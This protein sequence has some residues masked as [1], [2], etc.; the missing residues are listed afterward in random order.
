[1]FLEHLERL[2]DAG[3]VGKPGTVLLGGLGDDPF[4]VAHHGEA[5]RV[6]VDPVVARIVVVGLGDDVG[7]RRQEL[8]EGA[9]ADL[10]GFVQARHDAVMAIGRASLVHHLGLTLRVEILRDQTDDA[11]DLA[12]PGLQPRRRLFQEIEDILLGEFEQGATPRVHVD[13]GFRAALPRNG[14]PKVVEHLFAV[15]AALA[16]AA[17]FRHEVGLALARIAVDAVVHQRVRG[18]EQALDRQ[19]AV[20]LLAFRDVAF[21]EVEILQ[22][23]VGIRPLLEQIVVLEEMVVAEGGVGDDQRLHRRRV[24]FHDVADARVGV[25]HDLIGETAQAFLVMGFVRDELLSER[26][27]VVIQ[28]HPDGRICVE[29]L[30]GCDD[31][32]L[33][34]VHVESKAAAGDLL[35]GVV[36]VLD[37]TDV[38]I[39]AREEERALAHGAPC[40]APGALRSNSSRNTG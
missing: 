35:A 36:D 31:L 12:L 7:V 10:P 8:E 23:A 34:G 25:D 18:I 33:V 26:P 30:F 9:V 28:R 16:L 2:A 3:D 13:S 1:M 40:A 27:M 32:D 5:E 21:R 4:D 39:G 15:D 17:L 11:D 14:A 38:P 20:A 24:F 6:G 29:H 19:A 37:Q 22:D